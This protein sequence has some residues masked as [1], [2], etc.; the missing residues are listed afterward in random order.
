MAVTE[1]LRAG[2]D[3]EVDAARLPSGRIMIDSV[4]IVFP[5]HGASGSKVSLRGELERI[6][7]SAG[8]RWSV[9]SRVHT[10]DTG[11]VAS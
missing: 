7:V 1:W 2:L 8:C 10:R 11:V 9:H 6:L 3:Y 5:E 4:K